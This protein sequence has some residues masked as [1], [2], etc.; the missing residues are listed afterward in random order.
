METQLGCYLAEPSPVPPNTHLD[1][2]PCPTGDN[3]ICTISSSSSTSAVISPCTYDMWT[4]YFDGSETKEGSRA[5]CVL[6]EPL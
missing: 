6:I 4:M 1:L 3:E 2:I 5:G